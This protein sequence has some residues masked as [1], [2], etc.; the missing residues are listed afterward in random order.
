[1]KNKW[2]LLAQLQI[3]NKLW[4]NYKDDLIIPYGE[5]YTYYDIERERGKVSI[6]LEFDQQKFEMDADR[7][8]SNYFKSIIDELELELD[9]VVEEERK[10][11]DNQ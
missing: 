9:R 5:D 3:V 1:M 2:E 8:I 11:L 10:S 7:N 4:N 6:E